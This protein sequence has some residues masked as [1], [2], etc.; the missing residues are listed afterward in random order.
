MAVRSAIKSALADGKVTEEEKSMILKAAGGLSKTAV[1][2][3]TK[4]LDS[5]EIT[6]EVEKALRSLEN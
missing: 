3:I 4:A 6:A 2:K 5:G 1:N